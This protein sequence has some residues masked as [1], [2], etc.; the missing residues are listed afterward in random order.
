MG[1]AVASIRAEDVVDVPYPPSA[2]FRVLLDVADYDAWWPWYLGVDVI[3]ADPSGRPPGE[4]SPPVGARLRIRALAGYDFTWRVEHVE[5]DRAIRLRYEDGPYAGTGE[6]R[7]EPT[8]LGTRVSFVADATTSHPLLGQLGQVLDLGVGHSLVMRGVLAGLGRAL[9]TH[10]RLPAT[11]TPR[12]VS[13]GDA[14]ST[15]GE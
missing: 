5:P 2:V 9:A 14:S 8:A 15:H 1:V 13:A 10:A 6:W 11:P 4:A 3:A 7:L 12:A